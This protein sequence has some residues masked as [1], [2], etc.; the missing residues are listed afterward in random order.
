MGNFKGLGSLSQVKRNRERPIFLLYN[1]IVLEIVGFLCTYY[2]I[3][4]LYVYVIQFLKTLW[5]IEES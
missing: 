3:Y 1:I 5:R 4:I 2:T